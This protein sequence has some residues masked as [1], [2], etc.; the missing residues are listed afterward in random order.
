MSNHKRW[1][2]RQNN[3][4]RKRKPSHVTSELIVWDEL[5][6]HEPRLND[7]LIAARATKGDGKYFCRDETWQGY[8][9]GKPGFK[10]LLDPLV[11]WGATQAKTFLNTADAW[12]V[13]RDTILHALPPCRNCLCVDV[14]GNCCC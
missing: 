5:V 8:F 3:H 14:S 13:A 12:N 2:H 1:G 7:V 11:G 6:A 9:P 10:K 4:E